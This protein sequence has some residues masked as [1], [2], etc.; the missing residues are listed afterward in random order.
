MRLIRKEKVEEP[1][2]FSKMKK[3]F[4]TGSAFLLGAVSLATASLI[5]SWASRTPI[6]PEVARVEPTPQ[7]LPK[8]VTDDAKQGKLILASTVE[9]T[10]QDVPAS[11]A[12]TKEN[13][14]DS[15]AYE[16]QDPMAESRR[17]LAQLLR[18][19]EANHSIEALK[20]ESKIAVVES[21]LA[22]SP[23]GT[24]DRYVLIEALARLCTRSQGLESGLRY[25]DQLESEFDRP[26][27]SLRLELFEKHYMDG[28]SVMAH[29]HSAEIGIR[30]C[31]RAVSAKEL[32]IAT[33]IIR[34][35][36]GVAHKSRDQML[37]RT[38]VRMRSSLSNAAQSSS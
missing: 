19:W 15:I 26:V 9:E 35:T 10:P 27:W 32:S 24:P 28:A 5:G 1:T 8:N 37:K 11:G 13:H 21:W 17:A 36:I 38:A 18:S 2:M 25:C 20:D 4:F 22:D 23:K 12:V 16:S 14:V 34:L 33:E 31:E 30:L 3:W 7:S 6:Q 29:R